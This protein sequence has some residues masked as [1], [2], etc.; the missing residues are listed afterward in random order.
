MR[1]STLHQA[2]VEFVLRARHQIETFQ[3][4]R[5]VPFG[6]RPSYHDGLFIKVHLLLCRNFLGLQRNR[7]H[8][9]PVQA[10][11]IFVSMIG[12]YL[13]LYPAKRFVLIIPQSKRLDLLPERYGIFI[14][15][16]QRVL[17]DLVAVF[18]VLCHGG[19]NTHAPDSKRL[20]CASDI[21]SNPRGYV[22]HTNRSGLDWPWESDCHVAAWKG[23][24]PA[25]ANGD[26][27]IDHGF[28]AF[29]R[30]INP[31]LKALQ[32]RLPLMLWHIGRGSQGVSS[33]DCGAHVLVRE[34]ADSNLV[35]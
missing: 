12:L 29:T 24:S 22:V 17:D 5:A 7:M 32:K 14:F 3:Y 27:G 2:S 9:E 33:L 6:N 25:V 26:V 20:G 23:A 16:E 28:C 10:C 11:V 19:C 21:R 4:C 15:A 30:W 18:I 1:S 31:V 34:I 13:H 8:S 35:R